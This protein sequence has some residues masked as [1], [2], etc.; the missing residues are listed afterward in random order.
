MTIN[1]GRTPHILT[2]AFTKENRR[3]MYFLNRNKI[4][5]TEQTAIPKCPSATAGE[6]AVFI[7]IKSY[8]VL[9]FYSSLMAEILTNK[10]IFR[11]S[12]LRKCS[13]SQIRMFQ[14]GEANQEENIKRD[15]S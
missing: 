11:L 12:H 6:N 1:L 3:K 14:P 13:G 10:L 9:I 5:G 8:E 15:T 2:L 7:T 4:L